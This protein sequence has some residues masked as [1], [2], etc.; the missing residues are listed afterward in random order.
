MPVDV[1]TGFLAEDGDKGY[2]R[3]VGVAFDRKG[4]LLV[5][6]DAGDAIWRVTG[7]QGVSQRFELDD[8]CLP[9]RC[10]AGCVPRPPESEMAKTKAVTAQNAI[11]AIIGRSPVGEYPLMA[12]AAPPTIKRMVPSNEYAA[13]AIARV[14]PSQARW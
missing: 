14:R 4:A 1:L 3:P 9:G 6:D 13:P 12:M 5:A 10:G 11:P 7:A 2:G 8:T